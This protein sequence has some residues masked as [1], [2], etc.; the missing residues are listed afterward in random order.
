MVTVV[1]RHGGVQL[2]AFLLVGCQVRR[3]PGRA[4]AVAA[5][6]LLLG[7]E[8]QL[9]GNGPDSELARVLESLLACL[10]QLFQA[11]PL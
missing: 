3:A 4:V 7:E 9:I 2:A 11:V 10:H 6:L 8:L 5:P 1:P